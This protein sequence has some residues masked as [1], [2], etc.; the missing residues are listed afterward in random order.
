MPSRTRRKPRSKILADTSVL[1]KLARRRELHKH[2][3]NIS[4]ITVLE[5]V[6]GAKSQKQAV[7]F[8]KLLQNLYHIEPVDD[9]ITLVYWE[10]FRNVRKSIEDND[11]LIGSTALAK[12]YILWTANTKHF[13]PFCLPVNCV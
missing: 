2:Y 5:F 7:Q 8:L 12:N 13:K 10:V 4:I 11:L 9:H 3:F 1:I 6:R